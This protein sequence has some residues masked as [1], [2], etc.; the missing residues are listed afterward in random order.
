M[1][2]LRSLLD[3]CGVDGSVALTSAFGCYRLGL[4]DGSWIDVAAAAESVQQAEAAL[5]AGRMEDARA[6][7]AAAAAL[8]RRTFL[9][10]EDGSWVDVKR[11]ELHELLVRALGIVIESERAPRTR[12]Q[13]CATP[14]S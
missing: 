6:E 7:A 3:A 14:R 9:P 4:P 1:S 11:R 2:K 12:P 8:A 13:L 10:G 5:S